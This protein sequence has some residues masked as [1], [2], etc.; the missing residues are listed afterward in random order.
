MRQSSCK[1]LNAAFQNPKTISL[2]YFEASLVVDHVVSTYGEAGLRKLVRAYAQGVDTDAALKQ[3]LNTD[4]DSMQAGFDQTIERQF[5]PMRRA[6]VVPEASRVDLLKHAARRICETLASDNPRS[7]PVQMALGHAL[8]K[9]G[10]LED[11][12]QAFER[13]AA[14][15][16]AARGKDSPH[17]QMAAIALETEGSRARHRGADRARREST[18]TISKPRGSSPVCCARASQPIRRSCV[19]VYQRIAAIDP[20]DAEAHAALG[21]F[22]MQRNDADAAVREFRAVLAL[23][24]VDPARRSHRSRR[25]LLPRRQESRSEEGNAGRARNCAR[26]TS[27]RRN[28]C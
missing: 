18:S 5:G 19:P 15:V 9:A 11:A 4:F 10:Q 21:R 27:A 14:L 13:A 6:L 20:F 7:Y 24:P 25:E 8:R 3:A 22:A 17:E 1:D 16:P 26:A 2:A 23:N 28:C 12:M